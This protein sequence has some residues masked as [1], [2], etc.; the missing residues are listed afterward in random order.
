MSQGSNPGIKAHMWVLGAGVGMQWLCDRLSSPQCLV[1]SRA[2]GNVCWMKDS[3][4]CQCAHSRV[5]PHPTPSPLDIKTVFPPTL[6]LECQ[7]VENCYRQ[8]SP[9]VGCVCRMWC[10]IAPARVW[11]ESRDGG[12]GG[13]RKCPPGAAGCAGVGG[14]ACSTLSPGGSRAILACGSPICH[15]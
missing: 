4:V 9:W 13:T 12:L 1:H 14:T 15:V 5:S 8:V 10:F 6:G 3:S 2:S 11:S 7:G